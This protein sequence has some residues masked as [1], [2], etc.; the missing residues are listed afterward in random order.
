MGWGASGD[1][2]ARVRAAELHTELR[3]EVF[4]RARVK[5][6]I[7]ENLGWCARL[8]WDAKRAQVLGDGSRAVVAPEERFRVGGDELGETLPS[9]VGLEEL[10]RRDHARRVEREQGRPGSAQRR[11]VS[12]VEAREHGEQRCGR[13][14]GEQGQR[15]RPAPCQRQRVRGAEPSAVERLER[16][17]ER[18]QRGGGGH[19]RAA[20]REG[21]AAQAAREEGRELAAPEGGRQGE[22]ECCCADEHESRHRLMPGNACCSSTVGEPVHYSSA[23]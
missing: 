16:R 14:R 23:L 22:R 5:A 21:L 10:R 15:A 13:A 18:A 12:Q 20:P 6:R 7:S 1:V 8:L 3:G 2:W 19:C 17:L 9:D 11:R 4:G